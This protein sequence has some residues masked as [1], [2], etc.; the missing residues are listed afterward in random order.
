MALAVD[1]PVGWRNDSLS[2]CYF[3]KRLNQSLPAASLTIENG[4]GILFWT[5]NWKARLLTSSRVHPKYFRSIN[6]IFN[7][8]LFKTW[9]NNWLTPQFW[10]GGLKNVPIW[11]KLIV[12][13][14]TRQVIFF[15]AARYPISLL[16]TALIACIIYSVS[17]DFR[18]DL[19]WI[20]FAD[21]L[22]KQFVK[23]ID[24]PSSFY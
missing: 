5:T 11:A 2:L 23:F 1:V 24:L 20:L 6:E 19:H 3:V 10:L 9:R 22:K 8:L 15:A 7:K 4:L 16:H 18:P 14:R 12:Q 17:H 13:C 21:I